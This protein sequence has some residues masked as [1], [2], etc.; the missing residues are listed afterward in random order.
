ML[1]KSK[2]DEMPRDATDSLSVQLKKGTL[3]M[4]VL[5]LLQEEDMYGYQIA[6]LLDERS[7]GLLNLADNSLYGVL[8]RLIKDGYISSKKEENVKRARVFYHLEPAGEDHLQHLI[9][10]YRAIQNGIEKIF[11]QSQTKGV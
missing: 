5:L 4:L 10:E 9:R 11:E 8:Y 7:D 1:K 6:V 2:E 3:A